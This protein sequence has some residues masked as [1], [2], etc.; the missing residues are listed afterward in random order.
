MPKWR[1]YFHRCAAGLMC[2]C[3][4]GLGLIS[5]RMLFPAGDACPDKAR[6]VVSLLFLTF[7]TAAIAGQMWFQ[8][9]IVCDFNYDGC[10]L[11]FRTLSVQQM[12]MRPLPDIRE[13]REWRGRGGPLGYRLL[14][15]DKQRV[16]LEYSVSNSI[17]LAER[18]R[19]NIAGF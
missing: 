6:V 8:R 12:Q 15:R 5:V 2:L 1:R 9:R 13:V 3:F 17:V 7:T 19:A 16:Y 4:S 11:Q 14:F 10:T 18:L